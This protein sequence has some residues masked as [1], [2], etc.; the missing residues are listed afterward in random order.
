MMMSWL[1]CSLR[2]FGDSPNF[3]GYPPYFHHFKGG[4]HGVT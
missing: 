1:Y 3:L 2:F 4:S